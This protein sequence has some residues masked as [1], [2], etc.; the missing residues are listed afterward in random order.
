MAK[1]A[2]STADKLAALKKSS[3]PAEKKKSSAKE[4]RVLDMTERPLGSAVGELCELA[5]LVGQITPAADQHKMAVAESFFDLWTEE[6]F[7]TRKVPE[8][9]KAR[10]KKRDDKDVITTFDDM[11]CNFILKFRSD[12]LSKK[13]P[14]KE[15]LKDKTVQEV[16][17]E[18]LSSGVVGLSPDKAKLFV[19]EE[20]LA[21]ESTN[22]ADK[23][24]AMLASADGSDLK[25][26]GD[27]LVS[28]LMADSKRELGKLE[29][30]SPEQRK[31]AL[32][33]DQTVT[34]KDGVEERLLSYVTTLEQLRKLLNFMSVTKQVS[35]FEFGI[36]DEVQARNSR[37][38]AV[39]SR[40]I[41]LTK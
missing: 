7:T 19:E 12:G 24:E 38:T 29:P 6:M 35:N 10:I 27:F 1:T 40:Y 22:L 26:I 36:S 4:I 37:L 9:F 31:Q 30:L 32:R 11:A 28:C 34:L 13:L 41:N 3:A 21:I 25:Q 16:L 8:N 18:T 14:S 20:V 17:V 39:A 33:V 5:Y 2:L 23:L 15:D